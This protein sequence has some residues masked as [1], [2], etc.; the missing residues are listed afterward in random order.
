MTNSCHPLRYAKW[1][2]LYMVR[3]ALFGLLL[4]ISSSVSSEALEQNSESEAVDTIEE[5]ASE[6]SSAS[7]EA[8][9][10]LD[11]SEL[12]P[13]SRVFTTQ[14]RRY[15]ID[16]ARRARSKEGTLTIL[17]PVD[18]TIPLDSNEPEIPAQLRFSGMLLRAD[19]KHMVWLDGRSELS[20]VPP[21]GKV[22]VKRLK[23]GR[24]EVPIEVQSK[25]TLMKP[26]QVWLVEEGRV[27]EGY[28]V[29]KAPDKSIDQHIEEAVDQFSEAQ[30]NAEETEHGS[31]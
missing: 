17:P 22:E 19:G 3:S 25:L 15:E 11:E 29:P 12:Y 31:Q 18:G 16:K 2:R 21:E 5:N 26:G 1:Y 13:F 10:Q 23:S 9:Y 6:N 24:L 7:G 30:E 4:S 14:Q 28:S 27:E 20:K 8:E